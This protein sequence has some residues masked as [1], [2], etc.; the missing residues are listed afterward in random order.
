MSP[1][2]EKETSTA[3]YALIGT[4]ITAVIGLAGTAI[5]IYFQTVAPAQIALRST[6][7]AE[8]RQTL[9]AAATQSV[10]PT[11]T[12]SPTP[13]TPTAVVPTHPPTLTPVPPTATPTLTPT[14][15]FNGLKFCIN[16]RNVNVRSGP[17]VAFE[18]VG[19]L[20]FEDCLYFDGRTADNGWLRIESGQP[21]Y[22]DLGGNWVRSDLVRPPDFDQLPELESPPIPTPTPTPEG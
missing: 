6:Q 4:I 18:V 16:P 13:V 2:E 3:R 21:L 7:T 14:P 8:M 20:T 10:T 9:A 19:W 1:K 12:P 15:T 17:D 11:R 22:M 5:T